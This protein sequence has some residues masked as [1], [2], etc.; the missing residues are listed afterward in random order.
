MKKNMLNLIFF[1]LIVVV[2]SFSIVDD[3]INEIFKVENSKSKE[4]IVEQEVRAETIDPVLVK[5]TYSK[6]LIDYL[7]QPLFKIDENGKV[8]KCL[9]EKSEW[10]DKTELYCMLR[11]DIYFYNGNKITS[12]DVKTSIEDFLERSSMNMSYDSI[13]EV[14][15]INERE[16]CIILK[17]PDVT[18]E[19]VLTNSIISIIKRVDGKI[20]GSGIYY[21][22]E[23]KNKAFFLK[24]NKYYKDEKYDFESVEV[25]GELN[26]YQRILNSMKF[27]RYITYDLYKEDI[28]KAKNIGA[29]TD[30]IKIKQGNVFDIHSLL[31][32][33]KYEYSLEEKKA[34]ESIVHRDIETVYP[35]EMFLKIKGLNKTEFKLSKLKKEYTLEK[36]RKIF[37]ENQLDK[38][39]IEIIC[40]NT[41]HNREIA[42][43]LI[44]DLEK[45]G[46]KVELRIYE[47]NKFLYKLRNKDY[48]I[49]VYNITVN[50]KYLGTSLEKILIGDL[51]S[52]ELHDSIGPF[53]SL[54]KQSKNQDEAF[55]ALDKILSLIYSGRY[56]IPIEHKETYILG[57]GEVIKRVKE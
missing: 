2:R 54:M 45:E 30:N 4:L 1:F 27:N 44:R 9:L 22:A 52:E 13:K 57:D 46:L 56:F 37:K 11:D 41:I 26:S 19:R 48:D 38:R 20:I 6:R 21:V 33:N 16:F 28:E 40:L 24:K 36:A 50:S 32:G 39:K 3:E 42:N 49:A 10:R 31:F 25:R 5:D 7:Y 55:L 47:S 23:E 15:V 14:K 29:I 34:I 43:R 51:A 8:K 17:Y 12:Y 18:L 53:I 35:K